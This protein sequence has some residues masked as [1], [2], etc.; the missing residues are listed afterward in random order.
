MCVHVRGCVM[1][2]FTIVYGMQMYM[3]MSSCAYMYDVCV[4]HVWYVESYGD[5]ENTFGLELF[6]SNHVS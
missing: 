6:Q 4:L 5:D 3:A 2:L 1:F